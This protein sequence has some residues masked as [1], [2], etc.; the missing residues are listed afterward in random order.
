ME[1]I[2]IIMIFYLSPD[3]A[4]F[5]VIYLHLVDLFNGLL[6]RISNE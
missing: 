1:C 2:S 5:G 3:R 6:S 4:V